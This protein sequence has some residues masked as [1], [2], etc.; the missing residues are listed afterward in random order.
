MR[1]AADVTLQDLGNIGEFI[2]AMATLVT[3]GYLA[4]Q[5]RSNTRESQAASRNSV[6]QSF[7]DLLTHVSLDSEVSK[8]TRRGFFDPG[9]LDADDTFRFDL[10]IAALFTNLEDAFAQRRRNALADEDWEKWTILIKQYM[11]QPGVQASWSR[12][13]DS[14]SPAF[15]RYVENLGSDEIYNYALSEEPAAQHADEDG[16]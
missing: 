12:S 10:L 3:L 16:R 13:A 14:F 4:V 7:I 2:A 6:S 8:L 5:I 1:W 15:R 9:S 11:A